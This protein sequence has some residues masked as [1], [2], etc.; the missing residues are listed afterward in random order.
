RASMRVDP[1]QAEK[2]EPLLGRIARDRANEVTARTK[3]QQSARGRDGTFTDEA[4]A[5]RLLLSELEAAREARLPPDLQTYT[6][7]VR[8]MIGSLLRR[9]IGVDPRTAAPKD[10]ELYVQRWRPGA[11]LDELPVLDGWP[12][13]Y[14]AS[15]PLTAQP[16]APTIGARFDAAG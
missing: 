11:R 10:L 5:A 13:R 16:L 7:E 3:A 8:P 2:L 4:A 6:S 15:A 1:E 14:R 12:L 9:T